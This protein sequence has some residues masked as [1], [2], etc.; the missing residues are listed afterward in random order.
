MVRIVGA[1]GTAH[2][3]T[4]GFAFDKNERNDPADGLTRGWT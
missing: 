4:I 2:T 1:I 3:P